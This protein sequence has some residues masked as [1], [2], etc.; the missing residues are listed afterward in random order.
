MAQSVPDPAPGWTSSCP[1]LFGL[2]GPGSGRL[3]LV[4]P[5]DAGPALTNSYILSGLMSLLGL[6]LGRS[7][8][9]LALAGLGWFRLAHSHLGW[10]DQNELVF[11][12]LSTDLIEP[13]IEWPSQVL[14]LDKT[15][16]G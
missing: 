3:T 5:G 10:V 9:T 6:G 16:F 11:A 2:A 7:G 14:H 4:W 8:R 13:G 1:D 15:D 12:L